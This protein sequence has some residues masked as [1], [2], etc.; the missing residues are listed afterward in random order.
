LCLS[1]YFCSRTTSP[2]WWQTAQILLAHFC[3]ASSHGADGDSDLTGGANDS[4]SH[5][6]SKAHDAEHVLHIISLVILLL[7]LLQ[8]V[9]LMVALGLEYVKHV[10]YVFDLAVIVTA[11]FLETAAAGIVIAVMSWRAV[12]IVHGCVG[13]VFDCCS[14]FVCLIV[15]APARLCGV[16]YVEAHP[17]GA[18]VCHRGA[19]IS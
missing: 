17:A 15:I 7:F 2:R 1:T 9:L 5:S 18:Q 13:T 10:L 3:D 14:V 12:R 6:T 16:P 8:Q 19:R 11:L 4:T